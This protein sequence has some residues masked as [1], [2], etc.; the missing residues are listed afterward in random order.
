MFYSRTDR[1]G[2]QC[3]AQI[4]LGVF[5]PSRPSLSV[6][7]GEALDEGVELYFVRALKFNVVASS[8]SSL[9]ACSNFQ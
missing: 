4:G 3:G 6:V 8:A 1:C 7:D 9:F 5:N 2:E